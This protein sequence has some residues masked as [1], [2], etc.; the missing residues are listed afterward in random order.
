MKLPDWQNHSIR[1]T[2]KVALKGT[3]SVAQQKL[4][5]ECNNDNNNFQYHQYRSQTITEQR[6]KYPKKY[7]LVASSN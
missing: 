3:S 6:K 4:S 1:S 5:V 7:S 2:T